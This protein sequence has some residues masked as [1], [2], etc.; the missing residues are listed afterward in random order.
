[1]LAG[2]YAIDQAA[3]FFPRGTVHLVVV[4]PGVGT[5]RK[6]LL[7]AANDQFFVAPDNG[8]L[9]FILKRDQKARAWEIS[10]PKLQLP[11]VSATF[12]GR[13]IFAVTAAAIAAGT[14]KPDNAGNSISEP[15]IHADLE[16]RALGENAWLGSVLSI[17]HFG[18]VV[19]SFASA[20]F[21]QLLQ[22]SFSLSA[23]T[24]R[25]TTLRK[26]FGEAPAGLCFGYSG[27]SGF[28][29]FGLNQASAA[30]FLGIR[31]G[32]SIRLE[33]GS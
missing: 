22:A 5:D 13:D 19:T 25:I 31:V 14:V 9:S 11:Q 6:P 32:D 21:E 12:H 3:P 24:G 16:P 4:D 28:I 1:V 30:V 17:D 15:I 18:N 33:I 2:A 29:E 27:S 20:Y 23:G 10:N 7:A 8:V 26:S